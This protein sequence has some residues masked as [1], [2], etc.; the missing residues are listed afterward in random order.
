MISVYESV[1]DID[2]FIVGVTEYPMPDAVFGPTIAN[3]FAHRFTNFGPIA[4]STT[5]M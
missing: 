2:L 4:T 1:H 5:S 3:I